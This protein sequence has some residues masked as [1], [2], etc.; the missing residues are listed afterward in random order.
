MAPPKF[1]E[2]VENNFKNS[3]V[4]VEVIADSDAF[5][6]D[7]PLFAA[8]NRASKGNADVFQNLVYMEM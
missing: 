1:A 8:V 7:Y 3:C 2:Y 6:K 4:S 5:E